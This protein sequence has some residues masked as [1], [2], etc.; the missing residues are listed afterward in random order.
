MTDEEQIKELYRR[1][2]R[3]MVDQDT[4]DL[5]K[6]I[7]PEKF[8]VHMT[9]Y[10]Q[11]IAE[12]ISQVGDGQMKYFSAKEENIKDVTVQ[13]DH[14]S[15]IGQSRVKASVWG[16]GVN[17]WPLQIKMD[18]EKIDDKWYVADQHASTY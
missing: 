15:L 13:D 8:L 2:N 3:D 11:P 12:W 14:A 18:F 17:T 5:A 6:I 7:L 1:V 16:G 4:E 9:G 10:R